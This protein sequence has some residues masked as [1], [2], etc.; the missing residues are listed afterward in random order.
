MKLSKEDIPFIIGL[1]IAVA[2]TIKLISVAIS[3]SSMALSFPPSSPP[4][5]YTLPQLSSMTEKELSSLPHSCTSHILFLLLQE[6]QLREDERNSND[7]LY[8]AY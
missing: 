5:S 2:V 3:L 4:C 6:S 8:Y 7:A 1:I